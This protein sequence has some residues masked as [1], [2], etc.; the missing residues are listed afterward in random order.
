MKAHQGPVGAP[1]RALLRP[2]YVSSGDTPTGASDSCQTFRQSFPLPARW[3]PS[4]WLG[5]ME[6]R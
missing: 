6:I 4:R 3:G 1:G 2:A 5:L